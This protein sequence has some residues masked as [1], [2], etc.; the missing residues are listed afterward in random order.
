[1]QVKVVRGDAQRENLYPSASGEFFEYPVHLVTVPRAVESPSAHRLPGT[2]DEVHGVT[3]GERSGA[4][5]F[6]QATETA[7]VF[8]RVVWEKFVLPLFH[9]TEGKA[10]LGERLAEFR[11]T[12]VLESAQVN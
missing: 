6:A 4:A 10:A 7:A 12:G 5:A 8:E 3:R 1:M 11:G 2:E 9:A